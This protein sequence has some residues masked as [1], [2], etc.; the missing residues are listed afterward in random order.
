MAL[1]KLDFPKFVVESFL[2]GTLPATSTNYGCVFIADRPCIVEGFETRYETASTAGVTIQLRKVA[3]GTTVTAAGAGNNMLFSGVALNGA[4]A[5]V[6]AG[7]VNAAS[8]SLVAGDA[9]AL[10]PSG[11]PTTLANACFSVKVK[12]L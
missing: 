4:T 9:L 3:S 1:G 11:T 5:T 10:V 8:A 7:S 2:P 6:I 12:Y